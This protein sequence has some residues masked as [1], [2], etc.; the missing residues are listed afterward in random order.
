MCVLIRGSLQHRS[1]PI[2]PISIPVMHT[3]TVCTGPLHQQ[4]FFH[5]DPQQDMLLWFQCLGS[6]LQPVGPSPEPAVPPPDSAGHSTSLAHNCAA[7]LPQ[8]QHAHP[9][10]PTPSVCSVLCPVCS[11]CCRC[12]P[13]APLAWLIVLPCMHA[14]SVCCGH[15][16]HLG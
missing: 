6:L 5:V 3:S 8:T 2:Q 9:S 11:N 13:R 12:F 14:A 7:L 16:M 15:H 1:P 4:Q 10:T